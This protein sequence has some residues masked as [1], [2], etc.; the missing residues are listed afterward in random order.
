MSDIDPTEPTAWRK[1][2]VTINALEW[3]GTNADALHHFTRGRFHVLTDA[4]RATCDDPAATAQVFDHLH[5]TWVLVQTG[6]RIVEGVQGEYYPCR[7]AVF[8][9]TYEPA[10]RADPADPGDPAAVYR[11]A[12]EG[13]ADW[14]QRRFNDGDNPR[15]ALLAVA[16]DARRTLTDLDRRTPVNERGN[17]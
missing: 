5:T 16:V 17:G 15:S 1:I 14:A 11:T 6:D 10:D 8:A 4:E 7:A 3:T 9:E 13:I 2:P 12:I